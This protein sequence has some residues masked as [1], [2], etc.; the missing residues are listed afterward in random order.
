MLCLNGDVETAKKARII[1]DDLVASFRSKL[2]H[3]KGIKWLDR[4]DRGYWNLKHAD[5]Y[6]VKYPMLI[7]PFFGDY[8]TEESK[9]YVDKVQLYADIIVDLI[10][11]A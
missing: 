10:I 2:R 5:N 11:G 3:D 7:E 6:G 9:Q 4:G 1:L 8:E